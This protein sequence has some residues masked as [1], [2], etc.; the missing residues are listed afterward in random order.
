[1]LNVFVFNQPGDQI[2]GWNNYLI[3]LL[4]YCVA[5]I[6]DIIR[7]FCRGLAKDNSVRR[8]LVRCASSLFEKQDISEPSKVWVFIFCG[9]FVV[10]LFGGIEISVWIVVKS[11]N[12]ILGLRSWAKGTGWMQFK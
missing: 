8:N 2:P 9:L 3:I 12:Y 7:F 6:V 1:V 10:Y 5:F 11:I 4:W